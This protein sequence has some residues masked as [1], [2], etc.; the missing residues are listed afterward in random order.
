VNAAIEQTF[1][2]NI[3]SLFD[4]LSK[5]GNIYIFKPK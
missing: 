5:E 4:G 3:E 1:N 2:V